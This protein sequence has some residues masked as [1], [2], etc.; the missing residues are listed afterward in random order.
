MYAPLLTFLCCLLSKVVAERTR[1]LRQLNGEK[2][3]ECTLEELL[4]LEERLQRCLSRVSKAKDE[5]IVKQIN[6]QRRKGIQLMEQ[7]RGLE[8]RT[9]TVSHCKFQPRKIFNHRDLQPPSGAR[10]TVNHRRKQNCKPP[11]IRF[12]IHHKDPVKS[13]KPPSVRF[14]NRHKPPILD[15]ERCIG[16]EREMSAY[17]TR[18]RER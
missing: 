11:S 5:R 16:R 9:T 2:L 15:G 7:P 14:W 12:L 13:R 1:E 17:R 8:P 10:T 4:E 3:Q 6:A 18:G